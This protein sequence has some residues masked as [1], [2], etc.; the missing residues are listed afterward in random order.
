MRSVR[1]L[2][3][4]AVIVLAVLALFLPQKV[5]SAYT[6]SVLNSGL[7]IALLALSLAL[8]YDQLALMGFGIVSY[9][10]AAYAFAFATIYWHQS[11]TLAFFTSIGIT[12]VT[13]AVLG[14]VIVRT[15]GLVFAMLTLA[16]AQM[17]SLAV[18]LPSVQKWTGGD[19]GL[20]LTLTGSFFGLNAASLTNPVTLWPAIWIAV[21]VVAVG[22]WWLKR[23]SFGEVLRG[24]K[25]NEERMKFSGYDTFSPR[26]A[27]Y[28]IASLVAGLAGIL[29]S[30]ST[31]LVSGD[32]FSFTLT[33]NAIVA[34]LVGGMSTVIGP[35]IGGVLF[36]F[37]QSQF[38]QGTSLDIYTGAAVV[39]AVWLL[40]DGIV[41]LLVAASKRVA[42][43]FPRK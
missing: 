26:L 6:M 5:A 25:Q 16:L 4:L 31:G 23:S 35:L 37:G 15:N 11:A 1:A 7:I 8:L 27:V 13:S 42:S 38:S 14:W 20:I 22:L 29:S 3:V 36:A 21:V 30:V 43:R 32:L 12:V 9:G 18:S 33:G 40:R 34:A 24:I 2:S 41:G 28:V 10:I 39:I 19:N 17:A